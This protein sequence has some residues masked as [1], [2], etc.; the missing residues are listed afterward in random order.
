MPC[1]PRFEIR[2]GAKMESGGES[3]IQRRTV[4]VPDDLLDP[5]RALTLVTGDEMED[6]VARALRGYL[7]DEGHRAAVEGFADR[8]R[9]RHRIALD[10]LDDD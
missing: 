7:A 8:V 3:T 9:E 5:L 6:H 2:I 1:Q 10:R 4:P